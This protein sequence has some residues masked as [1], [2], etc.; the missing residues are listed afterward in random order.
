MV[1]I[2]EVNCTKRT[3]RINERL[4]SEFSYTEELVPTN[5]S[6]LSEVHL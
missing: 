4:P 1:G 2:I 5:H 6:D 3:R